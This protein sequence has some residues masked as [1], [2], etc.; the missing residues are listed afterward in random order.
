L[1]AYM[2]APGL[3]VHQSLR[4]RGKSASVH[5][6]FAWVFTLSLMGFAG[7][8]PSRLNVLEVLRCHRAMLTTV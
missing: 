6:D 4:A 3:Q 5:S 8:R 1:T 2:D 7:Q